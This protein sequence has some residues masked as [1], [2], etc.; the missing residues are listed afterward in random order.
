MTEDERTRALAAKALLEE[1]VFKQAVS[2]VEA[3]VFNALKS[4]PANGADLRE[5]LWAEY[6]GMNAIIVQLRQ[7]SDD[8]DFAVKKM[9]RQR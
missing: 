7:W 4:T 2:A 3:A 6:R 8:Y 5:R 9:E 1:D